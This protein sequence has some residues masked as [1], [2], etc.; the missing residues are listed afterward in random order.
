MGT[1]YE[2][3]PTEHFLDILTEVNRRVAEDFQSKGRNKQI[4]APVTMLTRKLYL[5]PQAT[6]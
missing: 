1:V 4:P 3:A 6:K 5:R 2:L